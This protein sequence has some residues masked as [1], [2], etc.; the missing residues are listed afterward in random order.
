MLVGSTVMFRG[1]HT[2]T[3]HS[4]ATRRVRVS[5]STPLD[6]PNGGASVLCVLWSETRGAG[7]SSKWLVSSLQLR[8]MS[9]V[10][11]QKK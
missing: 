4:S 2:I 11:S 6:H 5:W 9:L 7:G 3:L 1:G 10:T 8:S